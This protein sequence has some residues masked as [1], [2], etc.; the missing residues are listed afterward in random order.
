MSQNVPKNAKNDRFSKKC[1][2]YRNFM[3]KLK[4]RA[5]PVKSGTF[6]DIKYL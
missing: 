3:L 1:L 4:K 2:A 5:K 6:C